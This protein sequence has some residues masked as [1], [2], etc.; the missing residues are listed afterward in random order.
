MKSA[1][2]GGCSIEVSNVAA[3]RVDVQFVHDGDRLVTEV[4]REN[5]DCSFDALTKSYASQA[6]EH[7]NTNIRLGFLLVLDQTQPHRKGIPHLNDLVFPR[8]LVRSGETEP[9]WVIIVKVPGRR[10]VP[11]S[12][13]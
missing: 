10:L 11:S 8:K 1:V 7:Q 2:G 12:L 9:R 6:S 4:N 3:G 5:H 13:G